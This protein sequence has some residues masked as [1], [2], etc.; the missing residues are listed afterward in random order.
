MTKNLLNK[1]L[2]VVLNGEKNSEICNNVSFEYLKSNVLIKRLNCDTCLNTTNYEVSQFKTEYEKNFLQQDI[3]IQKIGAYLLTKKILHYFPKAYQHLPDMGNDIDLFILAS[4][5]E[6]SDMEVSFDLKKDDTSILNMIAGKTPYLY[7]NSISIEMHH[8]SGHFGEFKMLTK[9]FYRN[10]V[11]EN[12]VKQLSYEDRLINQ[13]VQRFYGHFTIRLSDII[14]TIKILNKGISADDLIRKSRKYG[15]YPALRLYL[16]FIIYNFDQFIDN[17]NIIKRF[18]NIE[19]A[20]VIYDDELLF[21]IE[22]RFA[23]KLYFLKFFSDIKNI[24]IYSLLK[25]STLPFVLISILIRK[26]IK[27]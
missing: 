25:I 14:Y 18:K 26:I 13:I 3:L 22:K 21:K 9:E 4:R 10:L 6:I 23:I 12:N 24:R 27:S 19:S 1:I 15:I 5:S 17:K 20:K 2:H 8:Y 11:V 7:D 16:G